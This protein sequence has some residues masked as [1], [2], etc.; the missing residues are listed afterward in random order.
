MGLCSNTIS[1]LTIL[2]FIYSMVL[3][4]NGIE[5]LYLYFRKRKLA[6]NNSHENKRF[7]VPEPVSIPRKKGC[8]KEI[9]IIY[10]DAEEDIVKC[11]K[12]DYY[13]NQI[14]H[15]DCENTKAKKGV[16]KNG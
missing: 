3:V 1:L 13:G 6:K 4:M 12:H 5:K 14:F 9:G 2:G 16:Q 10:D 8:G 11:G 15:K 7:E